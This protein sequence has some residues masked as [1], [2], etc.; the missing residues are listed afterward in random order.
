MFYNFI[1]QYLGSVSGVNLLRYITFRTMCAALTSLIISFLLYPSFIKHSRKN[2]Q[3]IR[4]DGPKSHTA[5][6]QGTPTMGGAVIVAGT[7]I[8]SLLW[9]DIS[10]NYL[11]LLNSL[12]LSYCL[13]GFYD[14]YLKV[15]LK[16]S[17]GVRGR[18]KLFFQIIIALV[19]SYLVESLRTPEIAGR[20]MFPFFKNF[21]IN[22]SAFLI[23]F[24][25]L[26]IVGSSNAV[27]LTDGLDGLAAFPSML[28]TLCFGIISYIVGHVVFANYLQIAYIAS[29]GELCIFC[30][31][32]IGACL[33]FLWYNAPPAKIF[34]GDT[35][36][37]AI[38][39]AL[40]GV[41]VIVKHEFVLAI[42][43][44][45]FVIEALSVMIQV[46]YFKY[47]GKRIFLMAPI[48]HHFEKKGWTESTV[49]VRFWII[50][51]IFA[52]IGLATL[53]IR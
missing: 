2:Y 48:H 53:K 17:K 11:L 52:V 10:N 45:L 22:N 47:T 31:A 34:M 1:F 15:K 46:A 50:S 7:L 18:K 24:T 30:G 6:K 8:S 37:L 35:G 42:I 3:P 36:S 16:N 9:G 19:F 33:G 26:V 49:V 27:N 13:L 38:G 4:S 29:A 32:L 51:F 23:V 44:G 43:G 12:T 25:T 5:H 21:V 14:D 28:A 20:L 41:S 40:G 39:G